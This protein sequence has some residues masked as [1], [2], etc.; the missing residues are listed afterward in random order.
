MSEAKKNF[1]T[2]TKELFDLSIDKASNQE[3]I[4]DIKKDSIF[5]GPSLWILFFAII[6]CSIGLDIN[7]TAV[8]IGGMLISPLMGP[9]IGIGMGLS[10]NDLALIKTAGFN[11]MIAIILSILAS[12]L[13]FYISPLHKVQSELLS[14]TSPAVWDVLIAFSGGFAG[15]IAYTRKEKTNVIPGVAIATALM[16]PLSTAGFGLA[17]GNYNFFFGALYLFTINSIFIAF[18]TSPTLIGSALLYPFT[19]NF[20]QTGVEGSIILHVFGSQVV[21]LYQGAFGSHC[22]PNSVSTIQSPHQVIS[23]LSHST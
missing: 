15:I 23:L 5:K 7:S 10:R 4:D 2:F 20:S 11:I 13:Y 9:I 6:I 12:A 19:S 14:R 8:I 1:K 18:G 22:S 16:P 21:E 3:I 17:T